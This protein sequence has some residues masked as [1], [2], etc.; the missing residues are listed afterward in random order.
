MNDRLNGQ[1]FPLVPVADRPRAAGLLL[2]RLGNG[3]VISSRKCQVGPQ[4][5]LGQVSIKP[6]PS[7]HLT[8][9]DC[10]S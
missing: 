1:P 9:R 5:Q 10:S 8:P 6:E 4:N 3:S 2:G 7:P